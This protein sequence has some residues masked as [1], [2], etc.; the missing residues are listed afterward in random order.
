M[1]IRYHEVCAKS[2]LNKLRRKLPYQWDLNIYRGCQHGCRYCYAL[3]THQHYENQNFFQDIHIKT[4]IVDLL[5]ME[6]KKNSW[7]Q[8]IINFGGVTDCYQPAE[9]KYELMPEL[10]K[11]LIKYKT[12]AI[13]STKSVLPMRDFELIKD[14]SE[15]TYVNI[16]A[17]VT[18]LDED[19]RKGLEPFCA[20]TADRFDMLKAFGET[21]A[22]TGLHMMPIIPYLTDDMDNQNALLKSAKEAQVDYVLPGMMYLRGLT[23]PYFMTYVK[24]HYP[25]KHKAL[26]A[27]Y[28]RG[29]AGKPY[30]SQF[31]EKFN[32]LRSSYGLSESYSKPIKEKLK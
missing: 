2:A 18:T 10:F 20:P 19:M 1:S 11:L 16:A 4:N 32:D 6:L 7:K 29:S 31:Y 15:I 28:T 27:L 9:K 30:K 21:S 17:S 5:E 13:I 14:L 24:D 25:D 23:R 22:S 8:E 3:Y 12:P 26:S